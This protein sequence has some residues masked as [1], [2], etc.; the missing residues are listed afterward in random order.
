MASKLSVI[1]S[2]ADS[3]STSDGEVEKESLGSTDS[4]HES[5]ES[6]RAECSSPGERAPY[7]QEALSD[8]EPEEDEDD[9]V[10]DGEEGSSSNLEP[11]AEFV[12]GAL[13]KR[14][15]QCNRLVVKNQALSAIRIIFDEASGQALA[16]V[17]ELRKFLDEMS[18][19]LVDADDLEPYLRVIEMELRAARSHN[20]T[21]EL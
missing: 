14:I 20:K 10:K 8:E 11:G 18:D 4:T 6:E 2:P 3:I 16:S 21:Q 1:E 5:Q 13:I 12:A 17:G 9:D 7:T 15:G 19:G